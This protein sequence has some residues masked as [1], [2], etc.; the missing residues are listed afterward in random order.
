MIS[1]YGNNQTYST[2]SKVVSESSSF[3]IYSKYLGI[4]GDAYEFGVDGYDN[5]NVYGVSSRAFIANGVDFVQMVS[6][7]AASTIVGTVVG[8]VAGTLTTATGVGVGVKVDYE[9]DTFYEQSLRDPIINGVTWVY[10]LGREA[11]ADFT[12]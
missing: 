10:D 3:Y 5:I 1:I 6:S 12:D 2:S 4:V 8:G 9:I 7:G 11:Y